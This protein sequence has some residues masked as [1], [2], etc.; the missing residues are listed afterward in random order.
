MTWYDFTNFILLL[1]CIIVIIRKYAIISGE[2]KILLVYFV[3]T[4]FLEAL[5]L[6]YILKGT[7]NLFLYHIIVPFQFLL[8]AYYLL[9]LIGKKRSKLML[10]FLILA[11]VVMWCFS[12][13]F[14]SLSKYYSV[15]G[16]LKNLILCGLALSF[17]QNAYGTFSDSSKF[18]SFHT[19]VCT[20]IFITSLGNFSIEG[21]M[22]YLL[23]NDRDIATAFY[24]L[25]IG[26]EFLFYVIFIL[27]FLLTKPK[28]QR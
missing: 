25:H 23:D 16:V 28:D 4:F 12:L 1:C 6:V 8:L 21:S 27:A 18:S 15:A 2:T 24:Y 26:W 19:W 13:Y 3:L 14:I 5:S 17:Y 11:A 7:N 10:S 22:N 9:S 20:G